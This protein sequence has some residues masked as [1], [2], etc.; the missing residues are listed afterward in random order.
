MECKWLCNNTGLNFN[1]GGCAHAEEN[2]YYLKDALC[3]CNIIGV[4]INL[5]AF[6]LS[7]AEGKGERTP[8]VL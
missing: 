3:F 5:V 6:I 2:S 7:L 4:N 1:L 8:V